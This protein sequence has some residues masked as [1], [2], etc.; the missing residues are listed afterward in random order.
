M[1]DVMECI[2]VV[3]AIGLAFNHV[4]HVAVAVQCAAAFHQ[5]PIVHTIQ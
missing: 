3:M 4:L 5:L 2:V 1:N